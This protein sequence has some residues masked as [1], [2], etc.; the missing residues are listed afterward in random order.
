[1]MTKRE[2]MEFVM[3][4]KPGQLLHLWDRHGRIVYFKTLTVTEYK[5]LSADTEVLE[6][7]T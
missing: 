6:D 1:M 3:T 2:F 5:T 7:R 4:A